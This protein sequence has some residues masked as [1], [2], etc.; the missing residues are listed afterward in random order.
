MKTFEELNLNKNLIEGLKKLDIH[1]PTDIQWGVIP[2]A[3]ENKDIIA[4][5]ETGTGKTLAYILPILQRLDCTKKELQNIVLAPTHELAMQIHKVSLDLMEKSGMTCKV[6]PIIGEANI[7]RQIE[8]LKEKP[9]LIVGTPGRILELIKL[10]KI[11]M[12]TVKTIVID[13]ADRLLDRFN[14]DNVGAI[15]KTT[16]KERQLLSFSASITDS[17]MQKCKEM[18]KDAEII[19]ATESPK[20]A[21]NIEHIYYICEQRDKVDELRKLVRLINPKR[22]IAFINKGDEID[23]MTEK[24]KYHQLKADSIHGASFKQDRKKALGDFRKGAIQLL[25]SSD[26]SSRGLDIKDV[27]CI[28]N[29]DMPEDPKNYL[30]RSGRTG[31]AGES[32]VVISFVTQ[33]ELTELKK[34]ARSYNIELD[35]IKMH[36]GRIL[37]EKRSNER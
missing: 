30:H 26:V 15:I 17:T 10:K 12:H 20:L 34:I 36:N 2:K 5:S 18:M 8:K 6:I 19:K 9:Q 31:R 21:E 33:N 13:E 7:Q 3:L 32:G 37:R 1:T 14:I 16:L 11:K 24:L 23:I 22:A 29:L 25:I 35:E 28:F 4:Q 27:D